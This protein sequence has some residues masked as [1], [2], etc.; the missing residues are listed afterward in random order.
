MIEV[1]LSLH[2]HTTASYQ[3]VVCEEWQE[4]NVKLVSGSISSAQRPSMLISVAR[5]AN[6]KGYPDRAV[7]KA[8]VDTP[9]LHSL[10]LTV[11]HQQQADRLRLTER[12]Q[13]ETPYWHY[14]TVVLFF[15]QLVT[16]MSSLHNSSQCGLN[17]GELFIPLTQN[18]F[19][20]LIFQ[21]S[22]IVFSSPK[23]CV[24]TIH[25]KNS[26]RSWHNT[27]FV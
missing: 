1:S 24:F 23:L 9:P 25:F 8:R 16:H 14:V 7:F 17:R 11:E 10:G 15:L 5:P 6:G 3:C 22:A 18:T 12:R 26:F 21:I 2:A 4:Q 19:N 13:E 27:T 20:D